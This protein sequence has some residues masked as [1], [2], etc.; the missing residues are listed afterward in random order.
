MLNFSILNLILYLA[1]EIGH[2][3]IY[4]KFSMASENFFPLHKF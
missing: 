4:A 3:K 2:I 1:K